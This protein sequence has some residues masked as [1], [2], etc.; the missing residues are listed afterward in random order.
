VT[1]GGVE[2][3]VECFIAGEVTRLDPLETEPVHY[4]VAFRIGAG[5]IC[6]RIPYQLF[7]QGIPSRFAAASISPAK[8]GGL[9]YGMRVE[10]V[11]RVSTE[12]DPGAVAR[13]VAKPDAL[14]D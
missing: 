4:R 1:P 8:L 10:D 14:K 11:V 7:R 12:P 13:R 2:P 6:Q 9:D 3:E 5:L